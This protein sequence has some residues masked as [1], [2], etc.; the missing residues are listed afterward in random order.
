MLIAWRKDFEQQVEGY[1]VQAEQ[2]YGIRTAN[3]KELR[4]LN[5]SVI[6]LN[7]I[8]DRIDTNKETGLKRI[9]DYKTGKPQDLDLG[10]L[11]ADGKQ[12]GRKF[13]LPLYALLAST[14]PALADIEE[15]QYQ[16]FKCED[17]PH[18]ATATQEQL[19]Q[20]YELALAYFTYIDAC[21]TRGIFPYKAT[22]YGSPFLRTAIAEIGERNRLSKGLHNHYLSFLESV[23]L[24][25]DEHIA[26]TARE[27]LAEYTLEAERRY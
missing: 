6:P 2:E 25:A 26:Q 4:L 1:S 22:Q 27:G 16:Y 8:I 17:M 14:E 7:G 10:D 3:F 5:G 12:T 15:A 9:V 21:A 11:T 19:K 13:Q 24:E 20:S 18:A 23:E